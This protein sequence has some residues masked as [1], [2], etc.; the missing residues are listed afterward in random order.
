VLACKNWNEKRRGDAQF[1]VYDKNKYISEVGQRDKDFSY[2]DPV[3]GTSNFNEYSKYYMKE[4]WRRIEMQEK[5]Y[6]IVAED[7]T[8]ETNLT[9]SYLSIGCN[10]CTNPACVSA[11]PV[12]AL[13]KETDYGMTLFNNEICI[14]CGRCK[15]AC[16]WGAPQYYRN[17]FANYQQNDPQK[18]RMTKCTGCIDRIRE[19]LKPA[20]AAACWNRA[21]D[22][23]PIEKLKVKYQGVYTE[24][25]EGFASDYILATGEYTQPN[26]IFKPKS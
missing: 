17:D 15:D 22:A 10:H 24:T 4:N 12:G 25:I 19:G 7:N 14:S 6:I 2:T 8:F 21:L 16:P 23:G 3:T 11:C 26:V 1:N 9:R 13:F 5:G 20:C 18:P